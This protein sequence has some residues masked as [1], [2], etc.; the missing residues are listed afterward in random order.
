MD[1]GAH[2]PLRAVC[3]RGFQGPPHRR[4]SRHAP[5]PPRPVADQH[6]N[7][8]VVASAC[9]Q[10]S[11][12]DRAPSRDPHAAAPIRSSSSSIQ[13][14]GGDQWHRQQRDLRVALGAPGLGGKRLRGPS[15]L[16]L[17]GLWPRL[18]GRAPMSP[19][20]PETTALLDGQ[21]ANG[22]LTRSGEVM[23]QVPASA[24]PRVRSADL[25]GHRPP[26]SARKDCNPA[27]ELQRARLCPNAISMSGVTRLGKTR[28]KYRHPALEN[29]QLA[30]RA[31]WPL[32]TGP[33]PRPYAIP[34]PSPGCRPPAPRTSAR[35]LALDQRAGS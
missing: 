13:L 32:H 33:P 28:R 2:G 26:R 10:R 30:D 22:W 14:T 35:I 7:A 18:H 4:V 9:P 19:S 12:S 1:A 31:P 3:L 21:A 17:N 34:P 20:C 16:V 8:C 24:N 11:P 27:P 15:S 25:T 6:Q 29:G 23:Q 5:L